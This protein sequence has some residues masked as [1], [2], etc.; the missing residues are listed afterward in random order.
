LVSFEFNESL[1]Q[2][3]SSLQIIS[4]YQ[5]WAGQSRQWFFVWAEVTGPVLLQIGER[6]ELVIQGAL[7]PPH[8]ERWPEALRRLDTFDSLDADSWTSRAAIFSCDYRT[9]PN[10][11]ES[12]MLSA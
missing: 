4:L 5:V 9:P 10:R 7:L 6:F 1:A 12:S 11:C 2:A 3:G 8:N